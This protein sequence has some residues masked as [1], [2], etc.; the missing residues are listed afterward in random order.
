V[1]PETLLHYRIIQPL[2][3]GGMGDVYIAEDTKLG[4]RVALKV[5]PRGRDED[6]ERRQR[7]QREARAVAALNHPNIVTIHAV[8]HV[9][10]VTFLTM[11]LVDGKPLSDLLPSSG[12]PVDR[13][14]KIAIPLASAVTAAHERGI[15]HRDLKP[16][17]VMV[18]ADGR[19]KVLD[20]GLAKLEEVAEPPDSAVTSLNPESLTG[21]GRIVG[22]A[23][24]MSPEQAEGKPVDHR[25]DIFS[26]GVVLYE[27]ATGHKP[28][29]GATTV[30][31]LSSILRDT[32]APISEVNAAMPRDLSRMV[33]RML[34][35]DPEHRYQTA[36]DVRNDLELLQEEISSGSAT[37]VAAPTSGSFERAAPKR[38]TGLYTG[39]AVAVAVLV[40]AVA[41][42]VFRSSSVP[43]MPA[44]PPFE[45]IRLTRLTNSGNVGLT[46]VSA[47]ARYV[48]HAA[49]EAGKQSLWLRQIAT[50]SNV[51]IVAPEAV[52]Y[53]GLSF[54]P[55]GNFV[56]YVAYPA[57][58]SFSTVYQVPVLGG[59]PRRIIDD[60]DTPL[61]FSPDGKQ[62]AFV[63]GYQRL[64]ENVLF[65]AAADG[66]GERRVVVRRYPLAFVLN[67]VAWSPDGKTLL[68]VA[69]VN[70]E[71]QVKVVA[72]DAATGAESIASEGA[73]ANIETVAWL[74]GG[75]GFVAAAAPDEPDA[76]MQIWHFTFPGG[77]S[78]R[79][80]NDLNSYAQVTVSGDGAT[81]AAVQ[82]EGV[83][84][85]W[86]G[87][88]ADLAS[89]R[90]ITKGANRADGSPGVSWTPDGRIV[91][92]SNAGGNFDIWISDA[93]GANARPLTN[94]S[95]FDGAPRVTP[96][97]KSILFNSSRPGGS[98]WLMD[99]DGGNQR[100]LIADRGAGRAVISPDS[101]WV[102]YT[103]FAKQARQV[104][105][106]PFGGGT[107][108]RLTAH[109]D[110]LGIR[111][112]GIFYHPT[113]AVTGISPD[114]SSL[115]GTYA[116]PERRGFR[117]GIFPI[118]GGTPTRLDI[119]ADEAVWT[120]DGKSLIYRDWRSGPPNL[121]RQPA[122]GG[123][124][125]PLTSFTDDVVAAFA[126]S[127]DG[128][129]VV[130][131]RGKGT[132]D[133]VLIRTE[134]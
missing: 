46:A 49:F 114:G 80:T 51:Q 86:T 95:S 63:R 84:H 91:Y 4:R 8:E 89:A 88:L 90:E 107:P 76:T 41:W 33:K 113:L 120:A 111:D 118:A 50:N 35:K 108:E 69:R 43:S 54:S 83:A 12:L 10:G 75:H 22:T 105:R 123:T 6:P 110:A 24:Y 85:L 99:L 66:T 55:D 64:G 116:D 96:D 5:L 61:E 125:V 60:V 9:E 100:P 72:I 52:R 121:F 37:P 70:I 67:N 32:P 126:L 94:D 57:A 47:D 7:F 92:A 39:I 18:G 129:Q 112:D 53:D 1:I 127:R 34:S 119:L 131:S 106:L 13:L 25:T 38:R 134:R 103:S 11:E 97:G 124:P 40:G 93:T 122:T 19:V 42:F 36:K 20:F 73:W 81:M 23:A 74:P 79:I 101:K 14:L 132:S 21:D 44:A 45:K 27:M 62:F 128:K 17:N 58:Q 71:G 98:T 2:G 117:L 3:S 87:P 78:R 26:L 109:W 28:F 29:K 115:L 48:V 15:I 65:V 104:W 31:T 102:Y 30:S 133:V 59:P 68:A 56:Y 130:M 82:N 16:A 77:A